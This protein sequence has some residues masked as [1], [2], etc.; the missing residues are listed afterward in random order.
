LTR[1]LQNIA[2]YIPAPKLGASPNAEQRYEAQAPMAHP[3][4]P[5]DSIAGFG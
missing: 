2:I 1:Y 4:I 3:L 5:Q